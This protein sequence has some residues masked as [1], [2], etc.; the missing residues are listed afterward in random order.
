MLFSNLIVEMFCHTA[1]K[2]EL[3]ALSKEMPDISVNNVVDEK[4]IIGKGELTRRSTRG[5]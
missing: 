2:S 4:R 3:I 5:H 1:E